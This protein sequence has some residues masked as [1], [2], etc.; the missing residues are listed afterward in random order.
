MQTKPA[1]DFDETVSTNCMCHRRA[2]RAM[3]PAPEHR[4]PRQVQLNV[5]EETRAQERAVSVTV[6]DL[7]TFDV[8]LDGPTEDTQQW[9]TMT[10]GVADLPHP[11]MDDNTQ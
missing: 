7:S 8:L 4:R 11:G 1:V 9:P 10:L 5:E 6:A 3:T 2:L